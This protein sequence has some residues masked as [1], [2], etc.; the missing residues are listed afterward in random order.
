MPAGA[1]AH[2]IASC[3]LLTH[4]HGSSVR[5]S[6]R[7]WAAQGYE[8][9]SEVGPTWSERLCDVWWDFH[10]IAAAVGWKS[11]GCLVDGDS[12]P[13]LALSCR[14]SRAHDVEDLLLSAM[15]PLRP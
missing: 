14:P 1:V 8:Q 13:V 11:S 6:A 5:C 7:G 12:R 9:A 2:H 4:G 10:P 15:S 3:R